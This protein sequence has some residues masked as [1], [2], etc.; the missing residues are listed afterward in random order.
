LH[1]R[2]QNAVRG[3]TVRFI[4]IGV[5]HSPFHDAQGTPIQPRAGEGVRA[6]VEIHTEFLAGLKD[7]DGFERIWLIY[8]F[9]RAVKQHSLIVRPYLDATDSHGVFATRA[10]VRPNPIGMSAVRLLEVRGIF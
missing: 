5:I 2:K 7:L 1:S 8:C 9:D 6:E 3:V 4:P 10:P